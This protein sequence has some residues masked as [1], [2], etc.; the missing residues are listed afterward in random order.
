MKLSKDIL[1]TGLSFS[2]EFG[3]NWL[4]EINDRLLS[5]YP[6]LSKLEL[7]TSDK[8][9]KK[10]NKFA[11]E[12]VL[13]HAVKTGNEIKFVDFS[14]FKNAMKVAYDWINDKNLQKLYSQSCYYAL[15]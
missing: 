15:K 7:D 5:V 2:M 3:E 6:Q 10:V 14:A 9:C 8:L 11:H 13:N 12:Y 1:N 4:V